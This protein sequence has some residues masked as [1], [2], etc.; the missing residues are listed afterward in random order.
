MAVHLL[1]FPDIIALQLPNPQ[2]F[3]DGCLESYEFCCQNRKLFTQ[4]KLHDL[5]G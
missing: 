3:L 5:M 1:Q 4:I 2:D